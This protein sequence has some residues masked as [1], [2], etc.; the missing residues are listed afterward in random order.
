MPILRHQPHGLLD[1]QRT[2]LEKQFFAVDIVDYKLISVL[3]LKNNLWFC[4]L[5]FGAT[6]LV[7]HC[8]M[9]EL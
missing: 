7:D 9:Q 1:Y 4:F 5:H 8:C 6:N 2:A 3:Y